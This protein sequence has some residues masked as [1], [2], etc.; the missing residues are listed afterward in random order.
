MDAGHGNAPGWIGFVAYGYASATP[1]YD[2][3]WQN[4]NAADASPTAYDSVGGN[5]V[6]DVHFYMAGR[7][8]TTPTATAGSGTA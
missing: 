6:I 3:S 5:V 4:A 1:I 7:T 8:N 2:D